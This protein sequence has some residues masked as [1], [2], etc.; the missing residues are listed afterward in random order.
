MPIYKIDF[1]LNSSIRSKFQADTIFGHICWAYRYLY[2]EEKLIQWLNN[3]KDSPTLISNAFPKGFVPKP[4]LPPLPINILDELMKSES[5]QQAGTDT[6][7]VKKHKKIDFI[8][9]DW[10]Y[11]NRQNLNS[12]KLF[13]HLN[14]I[15]KETKLPENKMALVTHNRFNRLTGK[16]DIGGLFD[17]EEDFFVME[18][19]RHVKFWFFLKS[20][21]MQ[22]KQIKEIMNFISSTGYGADKSVGKG[23]IEIEKICQEEIPPIDRQNAFVSFSNFIPANSSELDG[24]YKTF[25]KFGKLGGDFASG[26]NPFK[27]PVIMLEAGALVKIKEFEA[28]KYF[29]RLQPGVHSN[30]DINIVQYGYAFPVPVYYEEVEK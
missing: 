5:D 18:N 21:T 3:F 22:E 13:Q 15:V 7:I 16:A 29:G 4:I 28:N 6:S 2:S 23:N 17:T 12:K 1:K 10:F 25:T 26:G 24:Y 9:E 14:K 11:E 27:K 19:G 20:E 30:T 8:R